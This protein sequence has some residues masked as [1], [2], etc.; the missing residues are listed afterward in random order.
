MLSF[1]WTSSLSLQD[2]CTCGAVLCRNVPSRT[3]DAGDQ[4]WNCSSQF[5][6]RNLWRCLS[7]FNT[8]QEIK[9]KKSHFLSSDQAADEKSSSLVRGFS[10]CIQ[11]CVICCAYFHIP[12]AETNQRRT[13]GKEDKEDVISYFYH[14]CLLVGQSGFSSSRSLRGILLVLIARRERSGRE[15]KLMVLPPQLH[16]NSQHGHAFSSRC[17]LGQV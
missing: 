1:L 6:S 14:R 7:K 15:G 5:Q 11:K 8:E 2:G 17:I 9:K 12:T 13:K 3:D 16:G 10:R 4:R